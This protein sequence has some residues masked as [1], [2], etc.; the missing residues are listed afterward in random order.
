MCSTGTTVPLGLI[1]RAFAPCE[2]AAKPKTD[3]G[4]RPRHTDFLS[5]WPSGGACP[6]Q[7]RPRLGLN[8][9]LLRHLDLRFAI[10]ARPPATSPLLMRPKLL[11]LHELK[12]LKRCAQQKGVLSTQL[13]ESSR[14][15]EVWLDRTANRRSFALAHRPA[16][17]CWNRDPDPYRRAPLFE[18]T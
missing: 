1:P 18:P 11:P 4:G 16:A 2:T 17:M 6:F 8:W 10:C 14:L 9:P 15:V 13:P 3:A 7:R 5:T 12:V